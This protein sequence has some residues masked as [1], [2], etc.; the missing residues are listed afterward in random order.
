MSIF[1]DYSHQIIHH[2]TERELIAQNRWDRLGRDARGLDPV[3][4]WWRRLMHRD[5]RRSA[6]RRLANAGHQRYAH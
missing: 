3:V 2:Q 4:P 5:Q 6:P 1:N